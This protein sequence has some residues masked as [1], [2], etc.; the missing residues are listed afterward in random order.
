MTAQD[1]ELRRREKRLDALCAAGRPNYFAW[2]PFG[3]EVEMNIGGTEDVLLNVIADY[4]PSE[5][6][7][8]FDGY[9][10]VRGGWS[11]E[12]V[13]FGRRGMWT[14]ILPRLSREHLCTIVKELN[15][16]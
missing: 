8:S 14:D 6:P 13:W 2:I 10:G 16:R 11:I 9:P 7:S 3:Y 5:R 1:R 15:R 4:V 12:S